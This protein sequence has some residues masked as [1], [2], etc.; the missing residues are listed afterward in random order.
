MFDGM[1]IELFLQEFFVLN[2][3][4][5]WYYMRVEIGVIYKDCECL[6]YYVV[7]ICILISYCLVDLG[8]DEVFDVV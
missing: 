2:L 5:L 6:I 8:I 1:E 7:K 3:V 4:L